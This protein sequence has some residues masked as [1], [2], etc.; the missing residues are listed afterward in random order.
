MNWERNKR[1]VMELANAIKAHGFRVFVLLDDDYGSYYGFF[2]NGDNVAYFDVYW[3]NYCIA[4]CTLPSVS[5][6]HTT[7]LSEITK[8]VCDKAVSSLI[9]RIR[10]KRK[11][12]LYKF[13]KL[14]SRYGNDKRFS[15]L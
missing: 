8:N 7:R 11:P 3:D 2:T 10:G 1:M 12:R 4:K 14:M 5:V 9:P 6:C 13:D 15:E